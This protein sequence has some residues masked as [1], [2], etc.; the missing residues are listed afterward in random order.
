MSAIR[1]IR[2]ANL[3]IAEQRKY[4]RSQRR[5]TNGLEATLAVIA[6][7]PELAEYIR[8]IAKLALKEK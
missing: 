3:I 5:Y 4:I 7:D 6:Y 8:N 2:D 1:D